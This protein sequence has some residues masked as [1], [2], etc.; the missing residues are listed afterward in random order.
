MKRNGRNMKMPKGVGIKSD[1]WSQL[2]NT[3]RYDVLSNINN[4]K[5]TMWKNKKELRLQKLKG[6]TE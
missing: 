4:Y 6:V 3:Q 2:T 1:V 5:K